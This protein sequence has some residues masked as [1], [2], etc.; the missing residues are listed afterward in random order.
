MAGLVV[1]CIV[2]EVFC[3]AYRAS[4]CCFTAAARA[5]VRANVVVYYSGYGCGGRIGRGAGAGFGILL[6]GCRQKHGREGQ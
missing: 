3:T 4:A 2:V 5:V 1:E 6:A